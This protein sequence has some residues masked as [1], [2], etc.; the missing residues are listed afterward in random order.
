MLFLRSGRK[1]FTAS[2]SLEF[3]VARREISKEDESA[4]LRTDAPSSHYSA[5]FAAAIT[6][7][8][9]PAR[10]LEVAVAHDAALMQDG[11]HFVDGLGVVARHAANARVARVA[12]ALAAHDHAE[13]IGRT[14][15]HAPQSKHL[16]C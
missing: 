11:P 12:I 7:G 6:L 13:A 14:A 1:H 8:A 15:S 3:C 2:S 5:V 4:N 9:R 10:H 16:R